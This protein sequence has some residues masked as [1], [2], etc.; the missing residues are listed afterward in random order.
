VTF[1]YGFGSADPYLW[2]TDLDLT[3]DSDLTPDWNQDPTPDPAP[4]PGI[5]VSHLQDKMS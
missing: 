1:W 2:L 5:L 3:P 4:D